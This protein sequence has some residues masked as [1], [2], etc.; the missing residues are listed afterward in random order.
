[1]TQGVSCDAPDV[2]TTP[3]GYPPV[4]AREENLRHLPAAKLRR[5][6]VV[7][8]LETSVERGGEALD[9]SRAFGERAW[10]SPH[11]RVD[12]GERRDLAAR[13]RL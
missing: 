4:I 7:R 10:K 13:E 3:C 1:M 6:R 2:L 11:H 5:P 8:V 9:L 12:D